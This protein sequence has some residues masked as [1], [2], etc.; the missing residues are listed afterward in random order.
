[1]YDNKYSKP[2]EIYRGGDAIDKFIVQ[3]MNEVNDCKRIVRKKFKKPL[4]MTKKNERDFQNSTVCH[5]CECRFEPD[6]L[7]FDD[8]YDGDFNNKVRDHCHI[9]GKYRGAAHRDCNLKWA[10]SA[11]NL[12]IPVVFHNLKGYDCHFIMQKLGKLINEDVVYDIVKFKDENGDIKESKR[13]LNI[14]VI[15][16]T[17]EKYMGF[18]LGK[19][20]T[21]IDSFSFM[22][23]SLDRLSSNLSNLFYTREAFPNDE[24]FRLIKRKG[25]YPYDYM[26]SFQRFSEKSLPRREDFIAF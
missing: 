12:K 18:R 19:H 17:F 22:S 9:T 20:L 3:M 25:V 10:I 15:A 24:Q 14:S 2:V 1:M 11:E 23:Q 16:S 26:D 5:I 13:S 4:V 6:D 8:D 7:L 21:F